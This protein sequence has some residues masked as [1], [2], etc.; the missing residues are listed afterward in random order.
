MPLLRIPAVGLVAAVRFPRGLARA[1]VLHLQ[2]EVVR[3]LQA[4][5]D[6]RRVDGEEVVEEVV[7]PA[8]VEVREPRPEQDLAARTGLRKGSPLSGEEDI[9]AF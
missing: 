6:A 2:P 9:S 5:E 8:L 1:P 4:E 7:P 3:E